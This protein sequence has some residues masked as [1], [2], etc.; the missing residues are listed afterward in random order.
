MPLAELLAQFG[1]LEWGYL[2][3]GSGGLLIALY[4]LVRGKKPPQKLPAP[5]SQEKASTI[6]SAS[7]SKVT[8]SVRTSSSWWSALSKSR[9]RFSWNSKN[10]ENIKE[11]VEEACLISDLGVQ[12][13]QELLE[14]IPWQEIKKLSSDEEKLNKTKSS[15]AEVIGS[16]LEKQKGNNEAWPKK[17]SDSPTVIWFVGVNGVGKTTSIAKL[18]QEIKAKG[19]SVMLAAGDTFRAAAG[20]Q[21]ETWAQRLDIP[22]VRGRDGADSSSVLFDAIKSAKAKNIDYVLCDSAGRLHSQAQLMEALAKNKRVMS[23]ALEQAP[24]ETLLVLDANT[25]QNMLNQF[26]E[27]NQSVGLSGLILSKLDGSAKGGAVVAIARQST[28]PIRRIG[29]GEKAEDFA[30]FN[31]QEFS[32]ALLGLE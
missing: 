18:A 10:F 30:E 17:E 4:Y 6:T 25:G 2:F 19:N 8:Q 22:C 24:H 32:K 28:A 3:T 13:T 14:I 9:S 5:Q 26:T 23:K 16:W 21:L 11:S 12:N 1:M 27:F 7:P 29:L 15:M 31:A 20:E